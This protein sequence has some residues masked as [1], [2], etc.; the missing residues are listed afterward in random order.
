ML[1]PLKQRDSV[2]IKSTNNK[3]EWKQVE[4]QIETFRLWIRD[5]TR[6]V[7]EKILKMT[8]D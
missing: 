2:M 4:K 6:T 5:I 1:K 8:K 3:M 7:M